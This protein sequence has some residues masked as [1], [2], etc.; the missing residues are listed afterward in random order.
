MEIKLNK[1]IVIIGSVVLVS[2]LFCF[3]VLISKYYSNLLVCRQNLQD[4]N[5]NKEVGRLDSK[6]WDDTR[7]YQDNV[8]GF[9][10]WYPAEDGVAIDSS[11]DRFVVSFGGFVGSGNYSVEIY[12]NPIFSTLEEYFSPRHYRNTDGSSFV[13]SWV[14]SG[15]VSVDG[16]TALSGYE[17]RDSQYSSEDLF[18]RYRVTAFFN[19]DRLYVIRTDDGL[20]GRDAF[21]N[22]FKF[23]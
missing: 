19:G 14:M 9:E 18:Q 7:L 10:V 13:S 12:N 16:I 20:E 22:G 3:F 6:L 4:F 15:N 23:R 8:Y 5:S 1:I 2:I 11:D 21:I 17:V